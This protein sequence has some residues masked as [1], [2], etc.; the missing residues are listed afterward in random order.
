MKNFGYDRRQR[1]SI[2]SL[3]DLC[4]F[5][6]LDANESQHR[7]KDADKDTSQTVRQLIMLNSVVNN[8]SILTNKNNPTGTIECIHGIRCLAMANVIIA[9]LFQSAFHF[10]SKCQLVVK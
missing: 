6:L 5:P 8:W 3:Y 10:F 4:I 1:F 7:N 2:S 9:H